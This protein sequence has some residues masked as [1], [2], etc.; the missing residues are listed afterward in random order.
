MLQT[1]DRGRNLKGMKRERGEDRDTCQTRRSKGCL[2]GALASSSL[3][4]QRRQRVPRVL[5]R[6]SERQCLTETRGLACGRKASLALQGL[7][8]S[9]R[10][11][12]PSRICLAARGWAIRE[13]SG[14]PPAWVSLRCL[15]YRAQI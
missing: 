15:P 9:Q 1:W 2:P 13:L 14:C 12:K 6:V 8:G 7:Q 3:I 4:V 10:E 11:P 5:L